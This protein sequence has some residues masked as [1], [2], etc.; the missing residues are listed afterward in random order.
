M[1]KKCKHC[2]REI[3]ADLILCSPCKKIRDKK[4][5]E[6]KKNKKYAKNYSKFYYLKKILENPNH[7]KER[8]ELEK[9]KRKITNLNND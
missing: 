3:P 5:R 9:Q 8:W 7:N 2:P 6:N 1:L 4:Y